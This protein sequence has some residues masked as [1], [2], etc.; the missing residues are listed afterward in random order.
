MPTC[1]VE[2]LI[3]C[4]LWAK[5]PWHT[6]PASDPRQL[7]KVHRAPG[8]T[9]SI[10][11]Y[12]L[13][14]QG[15][16]EMPA[17]YWLVP[18]PANGFHV[19]VVVSHTI[20]LGTCHACLSLIVTRASVIHWEHDI[21]HLWQNCLLPTLL[22]SLSLCPHGHIDPPPLAS[23]QRS[24]SSLHSRGL[25]QVSTQRALGSVLRR[26]YRLARACYHQRWGSRRFGY[27]Q[28]PSCSPPTDNRPI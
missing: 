16:V 5:Q 1:W 14:L 12:S 26:S 3:T 19:L 24:H 13:I 18:K 10:F 20:E 17:A 7:L 11:T 15:T 21:Q 4:G 9:V 27:P 28:M 6:M 23:S 8:P 2:N 25:L 22:W